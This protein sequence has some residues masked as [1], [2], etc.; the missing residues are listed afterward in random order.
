M[1]TYDLLGQVTEISAQQ[2][3]SQIGSDEMEALSLLLQLPD[4]GALGIVAGHGARLL[5]GRRSRR[6]WRVGA[7]SSLGLLL[8]GGLGVGLGRGVLNS[9]RRHGEVCAVSLVGSQISWAP[10]AV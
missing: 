1:G 5:S 7:V 9:R 4:V 3:Q 2:S 10:R 6:S 8:L